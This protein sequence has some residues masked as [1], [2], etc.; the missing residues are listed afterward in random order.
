M[1]GRQKS[2]RA[3]YSE[4]ISRRSKLQLKLRKVDLEMSGAFKR[5]D[6][7]RL[8]FLTLKRARVQSQLELISE[9]CEAT[10]L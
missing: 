9:L 6:F 4:M 7:G 10:Y 2:M 8:N 1:T 3:F 5:D